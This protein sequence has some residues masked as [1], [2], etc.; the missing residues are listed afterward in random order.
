MATTMA[1]VLIR[2]VDKAGVAQGKAH[3]V[4]RAG[5]IV[6]VRPDGAYWSNKELSNPEWRIVRAPGMTVTEALALT[7]PDRVVEGADLSNRLRRR[8]T[9]G[10]ANLRPPIYR[11]LDQSFGGVYDIGSG[12]TELLRDQII[13]RLAQ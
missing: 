10:L 12:W 7:S 3:R 2:F 13:D 8:F 4:L 5:D 1:E 6:T 11:A 9:L